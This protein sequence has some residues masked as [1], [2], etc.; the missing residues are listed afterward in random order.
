MHQMQTEKRFRKL[1]LAAQEYPL[2]QT[3]GAENAQ[4][5][6][7]TWGSSYGACV[8]AARIL[9]ECGLPTSVLAPQMLYPVPVQQINDWLHSLQHVAVVE[10]NFASQLYRHLRGYVDLPVDAL[11][12]S[13]AGGTPIGLTEV[14]FT[15]GTKSIVRTRAVVK[16]S[17]G[18]G[19]MMRSNSASCSLIV[20]MFRASSR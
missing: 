7:L 20:S 17:T 19:T 4:L 10:L 12:L 9:T 14:I 18:R 15:P 8:E 6:L 16:S 11:R 3:S 2:L 5:G 13:R 1:E